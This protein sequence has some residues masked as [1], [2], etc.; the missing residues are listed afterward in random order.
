MDHC[1]PQL[2]FFSRFSISMHTQKQT[3]IVPT[4]EMKKRTGARDTRWMS[5]ILLDRIPNSAQGEKKQK[6]FF[7]QMTRLGTKCA[8]TVLTDLLCVI[9]WACVC[10]PPHVFQM[11]AWIKCNHSSKQPASDL[12]L[13]GP[14]LL[15]TIFCFCAA[16]TASCM[17]NRC[18]RVRAK[19]AS[20]DFHLNESH[21]PSLSNELQG[22]LW[23]RHVFPL[24]PLQRP[25]EL[26]KMI[27]G[28]CNGNDE[29]KVTLGSKQW[30]ESD[31]QAALERRNLDK[32]R[33]LTASGGNHLTVLRHWFHSQNKRNPYVTNHGLKQ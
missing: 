18:Q 25:D 4:L 11:M 1:V 29:I 23:P 7:R 20:T 3:Q 22:E 6:H 17:Q 10:D 27:S 30:M 33:A 19:N 26:R 2:W 9:L 16:N 15:E 8:N 24:R 14:G 5:G 12:D 28:P 13:Q 21:M 31:R 32:R